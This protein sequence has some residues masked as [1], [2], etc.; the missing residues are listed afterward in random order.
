MRRN[1]GG[2]KRPVARLS[3]RCSTGRCG[4]R[5]PDVRG[6]RRRAEIQLRA[7]RDAVT[8]SQVEEFSGFGPRQVHN[9]AVMPTLQR[10]LMRTKRSSVLKSEARNTKSETNSNDQNS[11]SKTAPPPGVS[12]WV[13]GSFEPSCLFRIS[14]FGFRIWPRCRLCAEK[15][16]TTDPTHLAL[17]Y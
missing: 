2:F 8:E 7:H 9:A 1:P 16:Y 4:R 14:I 15:L 13:I 10:D 6:L 12:V 3:N 17:W 5:K 11:T